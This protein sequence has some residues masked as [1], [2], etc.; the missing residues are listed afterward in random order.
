M[1]D[2]VHDVQELSPAWWT[3]IGGA[4]VAGAVLVPTHR[5]VAGLV[6]GAALV[7]L[8]LARMP[9]KACCA[10]CAGGAGASAPAPAPTP[11]PMPTVTLVDTDALLAQAARAGGCVA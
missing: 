1:R 2:Y 4:A 5:V 6:A 11:T 9:R 3:A 7:A 8:A 10:A